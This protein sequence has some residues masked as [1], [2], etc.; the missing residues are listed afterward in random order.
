[1]K[2]LAIVVLGSPNDS[3][4]NLSTM[5]IERC[6]QALIEYA[7]NPGAKILPTGGWGEHFNTTDHPHG[8]YVGKYLAAH[9]VPE[10]QFLFQRAYSRIC[11]Q[12]EQ[13]LGSYSEER[14][15]RGCRFMRSC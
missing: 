15:A 11:T 14:S 8:F 4:G 12:A 10:G 2:K 1:M 3:A 9:G 6:Q 13:N 5:G 7:R